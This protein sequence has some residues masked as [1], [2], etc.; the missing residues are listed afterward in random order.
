MMILVGVCVSDQTRWYLK[1][2][3]DHNK[4][5]NKRNRKKKN[6]GNGIGVCVVVCF[7]VLRVLEQLLLVFRVFSLALSYANDDVEHG[8][9]CAEE[10]EWT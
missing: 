6:L 7:G 10:H 4:S 9:G 5:D 8:S 2:V 1:Q 3:F